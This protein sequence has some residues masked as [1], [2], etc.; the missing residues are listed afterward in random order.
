VLSWG[1]PTIF[2]N[3]P[4]Y[5]NIR[6]EHVIPV[7]S[8]D[9]TDVR[10]KAGVLEAIHR[11]KETKILYVSNGGLSEEFCAQAKEKLGVEIKNVAN[12][13]LLSARDDIDQHLAKELAQKWIDNAEAVMEP[14][15]EDI[16]EASRLYYGIKKVMEEEEANVIT[17]SCFGLYIGTDLPLPC[18]AFVQLNDEGLAGVCQADI[19]ATLTQLMIGYIG[20]RPG[21][22]ANT[23]VDTATDTVTYSHCLAA[24]KMEGVAG[25]AEPYILRDHMGDYRSVCLQV[26]MKVGKKVTVGSFRPFNRMF[27]STPEIVG[28]IHLFGLPFSFFDEVSYEVTNAKP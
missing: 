13:R 23:F 6:R 24:T 16:L 26:R 9:F 12:E 4:G 11:L 10:R 19:N 17:I 15:Y 2:C 5:V 18:L 8:S 14:T 25:D 3:T 22:V 21:F 28:N 1:A 7:R 27:I 20:D